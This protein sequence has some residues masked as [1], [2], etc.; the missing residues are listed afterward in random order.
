[1]NVLI[2]APHRDDELIGMGGTLLKRKSEG[3]HVT[4]CIVTSQ[5]GSERSP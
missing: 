5:E 3:A 2:F 1:M 4:V